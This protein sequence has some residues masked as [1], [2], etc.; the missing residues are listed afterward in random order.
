MNPFARTTTLLLLAIA[1]V[2]AADVAVRVQQT[3]ES[4]PLP[5]VPPIAPI[6][7]VKMVI[8]HGDDVVVL[9]K[10]EDTWWV[11]APFEFQADKPSV[12]AILNLLVHGVPMDVEVDRGHFENYG[13]D[14]GNG[15]LTEV[16]GASGVLTRFYVGENSEGGST[17]VRFPEDERVYRARVGGRSR[18]E[19]TASQWR[20]RRIFELDATTFDNIAVE[21][22]GSRISFSRR[23]EPNE[24]GTPMPSPWSVDGQP[25]FPLDQE[26][27]QDLADSLA[28]LRAGEILGPDAPFDVPVGTVTFHTT[29]GEAHTLVL[30][31]HDRGLFARRDN[32]PATYRI[33]DPMAARVDRPLSRWRDRTLFAVEPISLKGMMYEDASLRTVMVADPKTGVWTVTEPANIAVDSREATR[34]AK[35]LVK[36]R[37]S[38]TADIDPKDAGF[39]S[40]TR[41]GLLLHDGTTRWM[42]IGD[43][44][45]GMPAGRELNFVRTPDVPDRVGVFPAAQLSRFKK[46]FSR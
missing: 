9:E 12:K 32:E 24:A 44:V 46:T 36:L 10:R 26:M 40:K 41:L 16:Y 35:A 11:T 29:G 33:G 43:N 31:R 34:V 37:A 17:F 4:Q 22:Q 5:S 20:D 18:F 19:H 25:S 45:P 3:I 42:E 15:I 2:G 30:A 1:V 21:R 27:M 23:F 39:P 8:T 14:Q 13:L 6:N 28:K 7:P 38:D